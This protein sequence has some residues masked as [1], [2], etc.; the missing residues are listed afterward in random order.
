MH[1]LIPAVPIPQVNMGYWCCQSGGWDICNFITAWG[2]GI[3][4]GWPPGI[5]HAYFE[6]MDEFIGKDEVFVKDWLVAII[7]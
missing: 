7:T 6:Q 1:Q 2:L 5:W 3:T 4:P